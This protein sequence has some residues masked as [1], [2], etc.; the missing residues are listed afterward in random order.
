MAVLPAA[1]RVYG[2]VPPDGGA[3]VGGGGAGIQRRG[4]R[5]RVGVSNILVFL[6]H[7]FSN[8]SSDD[9]HLVGGEEGAGGGGAAVAAKAKGGDKVN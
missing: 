6:V 4:A 2:P 5:A 8:S 1:D 7:R 3:A 9:D